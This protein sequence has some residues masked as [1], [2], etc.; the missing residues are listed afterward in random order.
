METIVEEDKPLCHESIN[1]IR[2]EAL[3]DSSADK[4]INALSFAGLIS[5]LSDETLDMLMNENF[6]AIFDGYIQTVQNK[7]DCRLKITVDQTEIDD[8]NNTGYI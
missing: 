5:T 8:V 3:L 7:Q 6:S 4:G 1:P 2:V